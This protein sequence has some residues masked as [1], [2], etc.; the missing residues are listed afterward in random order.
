MI[1][2]W[3]A[4]FCVG[5]YWIVNFTIWLEPE[6]DSTKVASKAQ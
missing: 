2:T 1:V 5:M 4:V 3:L 6:P